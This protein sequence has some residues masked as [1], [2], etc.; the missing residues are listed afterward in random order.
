MIE[1]VFDHELTPA[2]VAALEAEHGQA[3]RYKSG[4]NAGE[5][6]VTRADIPDYTKPKSR[7]A[8]DFFE[9]PGFAVPDKE[10][11]SSTDGLYS[12]SA[13]VIESLTSRPNAVPFL[14]TLGRVAAISKDLGTYFISTDEKS[15][16][17]K[18]MLT[19][20]GEDGLVHHSINHTSTVTGR[21]SGSNPNL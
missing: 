11:A 15:G 13:E 7:M 9:F 18:G 10:W 16:E 5:L 12:V 17:Q 3:L 20:V 8:D 2:E 1:L 19:F 14:K 21:F 4:K 6:K